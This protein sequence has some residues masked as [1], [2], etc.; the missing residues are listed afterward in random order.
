ML[1]FLSALSLA[2]CIVMT[3]YSATTTSNKGGQSLKDSIKEAWTNIFVGFTINYIANLLI[4]PLAMDSGE[5][6]GFLNNF[7]MGWIYTAI[8]MIRQF[9]IRRR[10]NNKM[11]SSMVTA[12]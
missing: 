10:Y 6:V 1:L 5:G 3:W 4:L 9:V 12:K 2:A 11:L 7:L 8:S